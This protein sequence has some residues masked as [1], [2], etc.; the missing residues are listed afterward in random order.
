MDIRNRNNN[1]FSLI[2]L[3]VVVTIIAITSAMMLI[4]YKRDEAKDNLLKAAGQFQ[5]LLRGAAAAGLAV[6]RN[7]CVRLDGAAANDMEIWID[8]NYDRVKDAS[9]FTIGTY[10]IPYSNVK[11]EFIKPGPLGPGLLEFLHRGDARYN[12]DGFGTITNDPNYAAADGVFL[13]LCTGPVTPATT[14]LTRWFSFK[15]YS[16]TSFVEVI[17]GYAP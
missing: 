6:G 16:R 4:R 15:L 13:R 11:L 1:G 14:D 12:Q 10:N 8:Q 7:V 17:K 9:E 2:E 5:S 3:L